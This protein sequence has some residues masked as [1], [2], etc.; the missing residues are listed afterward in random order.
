MLWA[1]PS[2]P[3]LTD[4][5]L[6]SYAPWEI[7]GSYTVVDGSPGAAALIRRWDVTAIL[8][9]N[10]QGVENLSSEGFRVRFHG[11]QGFY[12]VQPGAGD[13]GRGERGV[14]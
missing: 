2:A 3:I 12:L 1:N 7:D 4:G 11:G 9:R 13:C 10:T 6:E 5:R 8:T 14:R